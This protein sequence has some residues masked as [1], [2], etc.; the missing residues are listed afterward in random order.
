VTVSLGALS[1]V[2]GRVSEAVE[3]AVDEAWNKVGNGK[4][5]DTSGTQPVRFRPS[6]PLLAFLQGL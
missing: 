5:K 1:A 6:D 4:V 2:E 3:P